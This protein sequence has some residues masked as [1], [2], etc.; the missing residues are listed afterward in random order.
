MTRNQRKQKRLNAQRIIGL[1]L[2][3]MAV[4]VFVLCRGTGEDCG[5]GVLL[6]PLGAVLFLSKN[7]LI[8]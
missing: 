3:L 4:A 1:V 8:F 6:A 7:I 2:L 5:F